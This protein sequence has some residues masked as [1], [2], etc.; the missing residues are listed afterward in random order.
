MALWGAAVIAGQTVPTPRPRSRAA[1]AAALTAAVPNSLFP[2]SPPFVPC[3]SLNR[4]PTPRA[5]RPPRA[6]ATLV[7]V[8]DSPAG[9]EVLLSQRAERGDHNSGA[10]VFPG[11]L[12]DAARCRGASVVRRSRRCDRE[13]A[14]RAGPRRPRLLHRRGARML[15]GIGPAV[16][17][18]SGGRAGPARRR[19]RRPARR[20]AQHPAPQRVRARRPVPKPRAAAGGRPAGLPQPLADAD[21][22]PEAFRHALLHRRGAAGADRRARWHR[23]GRAAVAAA[24]RGLARQPRCAS[25]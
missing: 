23:D 5:D 8:R 3:P 24:G 22:P 19:C 16:R 10:W 17:L 18:R 21:R 14:P 6:S 2:T 4:H 1:T 25:C 7:V 9:I 15:R 20:L 11:G 12:V 13:R